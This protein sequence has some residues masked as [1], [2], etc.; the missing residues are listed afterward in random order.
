[1]NTADTIE[2]HVIAHII[3]MQVRSDCKYS[4]SEKAHRVLL[5]SRFL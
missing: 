1:M 4:R 5:Q 2:L 3:Y